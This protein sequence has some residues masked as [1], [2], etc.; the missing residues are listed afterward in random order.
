MLE[1]VAENLTVEYDLI[2]E[3]ETLT[4][5]WNFSLTIPAGEFLVVVGP[6]GCGKTTF[7]NVVVGLVK[8]SKGR[9]LCGGKL[10]NGPGSD[11]AMVFQDY[12]LMPWRTIQK[13][14]EFGLE[15]QGR[16]NG[17]AARNVE[18]YINLVGL[19]GFEQNLPHELSGGMRQRVGLARALATEPKVLTMDE[20]FGALDAMTREIMQAEFEKILSKTK[21]TVVFITH[22]IDEAITMGDRV[23][24]MT[25]GPGRI[26]AILDID[27]PR[28][29]WA[30]DVREHPRY[31]ELRHEIWHMLKSEQQAQMDQESEPG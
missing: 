30:I 4:A 17:D 12:A 16:L 21:Q 9:V 11:R 18:H 23:V 19:R 5:L 15:L 24:V 14:V 3:K 8:A 29:R 1:V 2:R 27:I 22:S 20:P 31:P 6:S 26:K 28:P 25:A 13:N 7:I 10:I